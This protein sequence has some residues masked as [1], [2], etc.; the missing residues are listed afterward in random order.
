MVIFSR[1]TWVSRYQN[2]SILDLL[3]AKDDGSGGG[4]RSYSRKLQWKA[5]VTSSPPT[6]H[7][8]S[9]LQAECAL[10][11]NRVKAPNGNGLLKGL[12]ILKN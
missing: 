2:V 10:S 9:F 3:G 12:I 7:I 6:N 8:L 11:P 1:R 5:P 4:N